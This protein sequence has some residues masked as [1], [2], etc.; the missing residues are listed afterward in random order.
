MVSLKK[1]CQI[2]GKIWIDHNRTETQWQS[3][4]KHYH[5][6]P[7]PLEKSDQNF[8]STT[9]LHEQKQIFLPFDIVQVCNRLKFMP[10]IV[11]KLCCTLLSHLEWLSSMI[12]IWAQWADAHCRHPVLGLLVLAKTVSLKSFQESK[13]V[14]DPC[15]KYCIWKI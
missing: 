9:P 12:R 4:S 7:K 15:Y 2:G 8:S 14:A 5:T 6:T 1:S 11:P 3:W 13:I 10:K